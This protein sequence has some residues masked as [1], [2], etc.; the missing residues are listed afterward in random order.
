MRRVFELVSVLFICCVFVSCASITKGRYQTIPV[1]TQPPGATAQVDG[2][3]IITPGS[4]SLRRDR[5]Y[6]VMIEKEGY[7][8]QTVKLT[9]TISGAVAG[10]LLIGGIIGGAIDMGTGAAYKL[11][12]E[13]IDVLLQPLQSPSPE[14]DE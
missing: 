4:F 9:K 3:K 11:V 13:E 2:Q 8:T 10:N 12:P 7:V 6:T 14:A 5:S 1:S